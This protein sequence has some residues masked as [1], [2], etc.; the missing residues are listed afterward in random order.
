[1]HAPTR[2]PPTRGPVGVNSRYNFVVVE[3]NLGINLIWANC[4]YLQG[5]FH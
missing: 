1:M 2:G 4:N 5:V 3:H